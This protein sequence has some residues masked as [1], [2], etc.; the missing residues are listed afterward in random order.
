MNSMEQLE[1]L[2]RHYNHSFPMNARFKRKDNRIYF[3]GDFE[4]GE[5]ITFDTMCSKP[6]ACGYG[7]A[8][9]KGTTGTAK[10]IHITE[11]Y[12]D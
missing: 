2:R 7:N 8:W 10:L 5:E 4:D 1:Y 9:H 6:S 11:V 3:V 12:N